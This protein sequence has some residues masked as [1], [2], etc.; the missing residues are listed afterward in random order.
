MS[1]KIRTPPIYN[2]IR[3]FIISIVIVFLPSGMVN[4]AQGQT[5]PVIIPSTSIEYQVPEYIP[6]AEELRHP[7]HF[8]SGRTYRI[9]Y[10]FPT[11][12]SID[13]VA[14]ELYGTTSQFKSL[15]QVKEAT[16]AYIDAEVPLDIP[17]DTYKIR[18]TISQ[19]I[20]E[21]T[22]DITGLTD[23][24]KKSLLGGEGRGAGIEPLSPAVSY[25]SEINCT[26]DSIPDDCF[27]ESVIAGDPTNPDDIVFAWSSDKKPIQPF[28]VS[29]NSGKT[30][31]PL[32]LTDYD[33]RKY[34]CDPKALVTLQGTVLISGIGDGGAGITGIL[35]QG[36]VT[37]STLNHTV[38]RNTPG[39]V[40]TGINMDFIKLAY[41]TNSGTIYIAGAINFG[42]TADEHYDFGLLV[43]HDSGQSFSLLRLPRYSLLPAQ[44]SSMD[45]TPEG[46]LR[47]YDHREDRLLRFNASADSFQN[48]PGVDSITFA[49][50]AFISANDL[51]LWKVW[52]GPEIAIDKSSGPHRGRIYLVW[53]K[54][55]TIIIAQ[56][57]EFKRYGKDYNIFL[58][59]S[60]DDGAS[61]SRPLRVNDDA[62]IADQVFPSIRVDREGNVHISFIDKREN[63]DGVP[64]DIYYTVIRDGRISKNIRVNHEHYNGNQGWRDPGDYMD[65]VVGYPSKAYVSYPCQKDVDYNGRLVRVTDTCIAAIDPTLIPESDQIRFLRG[66]SNRDN[67]VDISD[68]IFTLTYLFLNNNQPPT[69]MDAVDANDDGKVDISDAI[70]T[71][72]YLFLG[73]PTE[74]KPPFSYLGIDPTADGLNCQ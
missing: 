49:R 60:D 28:W 72:G 5:A 19:T 27:L 23:Q 4:L 39:P 6:N 43:S 22:I 48:I 9:R 37:G 10:S 32:T 71:L 52:S 62:T 29:H 42:T 30:W 18:I 73:N 44:P 68:A 54:A 3:L 45:T 25:H 56:E 7:Q 61:W 1:G 46:L 47:V 20:Y 65:M 12:Q 53:S 63:P 26:M 40:P 34:C 2:F 8:F 35:F 21:T 57:L 38:V 66:D 67:N 58:A 59:Y 16:T 55:E 24:E 41:D 51:R 64:Y 17:T 31:E 74:L 36:P 50:G 69:C 15:L 14:A 70:T 13:S 11:V 33:Y